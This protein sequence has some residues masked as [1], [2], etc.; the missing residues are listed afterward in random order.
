MNTIRAVELPLN[1]T[2]EYDEQD[3]NCCGTTV[4]NNEMQ[5]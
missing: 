2:K 5:K 4:C 3:Y 1:P